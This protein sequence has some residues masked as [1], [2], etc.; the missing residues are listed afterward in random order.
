MTRALRSLL[1][2][3]HRWLGLSL[4]FFVL[5]LSV[6]G[7]ALNH[8]ETWQLDKK[9]IPS[10]LASLYI[11]TPDLTGFKVTEGLVYQAGHTLYLNEHA[12]TSCSETLIGAAEISGLIIT[13]C[14]GELLAFLGS[15]QLVE[16]L[17]AA[18]GVPSP[19]T[20]LAMN[21]HMEGAF[22][23][24][25]NDEG[26]Y[27]YNME[28]LSSE[29]ILVSDESMMQASPAEIPANL[30]L[31]GAITWERLVLD[32]HAGRWPGFSSTWFLDAVAGLLIVLALSGIGIYFRPQR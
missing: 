22:V 32:L 11:E 25:G 8:G 2:T 26:W 9:T 27:R 1:R 16:R 30:A 28:E 24:V 19:I 5:F 31:G 7:L 14:E 3:A 12:V 18:H 6:T 21:P 17:G 10:W 15:G 23:F 29:S 20:R 13:A 4:A